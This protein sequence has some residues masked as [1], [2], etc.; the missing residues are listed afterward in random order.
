MWN[1][2]TCTRQSGLSH[3]ATGRLVWLAMTNMNII[4]LQEVTFGKMRPN[5][6]PLKYATTTSK[7]CQ[8]MTQNGASI[9]AKCIRDVGKVC[10]SSIMIDARPHHNTPI[11]LQ[12]VHYVSDKLFRQLSREDS[13]P[14]RIY[15]HHGTGITRCA[16]S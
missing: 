8:N 1:V 4:A 11:I 14:I 16:L 15:R 7:E 10:V 13:L 9:L 6:I 5:I 3:W 2:V 12:N